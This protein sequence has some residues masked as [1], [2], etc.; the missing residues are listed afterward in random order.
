MPD[1]GER[2][3]HHEQDYRQPSAD[4]DVPESYF[5]IRAWQSSKVGKTTITL[6]NYSLPMS[7]FQTAG[8]AR[9]YSPN[10]VTH[11]SESRSMTF[12]PSDCSHS[13]PPWKLRLSPTTNVLKPN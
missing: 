12:T 10:R 11:S 8:F 13:T 7:S 2:P 9:M 5:L 4:S 6:Q 3:G 1:H